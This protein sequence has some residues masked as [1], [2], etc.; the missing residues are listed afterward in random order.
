M[1]YKIYLVSLRMIFRT[2]DLD[3]IFTLLPNAI[4]GS[5][6]PASVFINIQ[7][8]YEVVLILILNRSLMLNFFIEYNI[9]SRSR[10][11]L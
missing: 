6:A 11:F 3:F 9:W 8:Q 2:I 10:G 1:C 4:L 7:Y 5:S